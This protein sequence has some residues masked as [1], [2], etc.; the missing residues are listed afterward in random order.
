MAFGQDN[1]F[2]IDFTENQTIIPISYRS[3]ANPV[4]EVKINGK[5]PYKFMFDTGSP[6]LAKLDEKVFTELNLPVTDSIMAGDGSGINRKAF[7]VTG[8]RQIAIGPYKINNVAAMVRDYNQRKNIDPID[9]VIGLGFFKDVL[10][11]LNFEKNQLIISKGKLDKND[12]NVFPTAMKNDVP[13]IDLKLGTKSTNAVFDTGNMGWLSLHS[14]VI[15]NE[16]IMGTPKVIGRAKTVSNE[17]EIREAQLKESIFI[18]NIEFG[19]PTIIINDVLPQTNA[20]IR[21]LKQ[22]NITFDQKN[23]LVRLI[24]FEP[25]VAASKLGTVNEYAGKYGD[26]TITANNDGTLSIQRPGGM[27]MKMT[28]KAK[29]EFSLE[30][31]P[32]ALI[33]FERDSNKKIIAVKVSK[34]DGNWET[35]SKD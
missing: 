29:D 2:S 16:M 10:V 7:P 32:N 23:G 28:A 24:K 15:S 14:S 25:Q 20:G 13:T 21:F 35:S 19:N 11:E 5:G 30:M 26:R 12:K 33:V 4:I 18:G 31:V 34:G 6:T 3:G 1:S 22:M 8:L 17:F 9:G 27:P